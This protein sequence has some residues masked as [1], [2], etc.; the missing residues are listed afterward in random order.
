MSYERTK[1]ADLIAMLIKRD[2]QV[3]EL[4]ETLER[5]V[6]ESENLTKHIAKQDAQMA[7]LQARV[8]QLAGEAA[9]AKTQRM[10][11]A[12]QRNARTRNM[13]ILKLLQERYKT[14]ARTARNNEK[15]GY[16]VFSKKR[17]WVLVPTDVINELS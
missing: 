13:A 12:Q 5:T 1:K 6:E 17:G 10:G 8:Q 16:Y 11:E 14:T 9:V 4:R 15:P 2:H 3:A 7:E